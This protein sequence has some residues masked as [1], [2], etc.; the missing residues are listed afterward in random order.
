[1]ASEWKKLSLR[2][3]PRVHYTIM[4][5]CPNPTKAMRHLLNLYA[6]SLVEQKYQGNIVPPQYDV[7]F[8]ELDTNDRD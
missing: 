4:T 2:L 1:M 6:K 3:D 7:K 8:E 5:L